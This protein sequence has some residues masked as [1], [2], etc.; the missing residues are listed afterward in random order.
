M[1]AGLPSTKNW[2]W[3]LDR[4]DQNRAC[5]EKDGGDVIQTGAFVTNERLVEAFCSGEVPFAEADFMFLNSISY[6]WNKRKSGDN[7]FT[8][9][10]IEEILNVLASMR[11]SLPSTLSQV[12]F[13]K[14]VASLASPAPLSFAH[15]YLRGGEK[16]EVFAIEPFRGGEWVVSVIEQFN[17][18]MSFG[19]TARLDKFELIAV[20]GRALIPS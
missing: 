1:L 14:K 3:F 16:R 13:S 19:L 18:E 7:E 2:Y 5:I 6:A 10:D 15:L 9:N 11:W 20:P 4:E 8:E 12:M 17:A